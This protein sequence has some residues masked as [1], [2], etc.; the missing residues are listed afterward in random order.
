[1]DEFFVYDKFTLAGVLREYSFIKWTR[2]FNQTGEFIMET[3]ATDDM[4]RYIK[5]GRILYKGVNGEAAIIEDFISIRDALGS[6]ILTV[7]GRF[8]S[9]IL[10]YRVFSYTGTAA[11][12]VIINAIMDQNFISP[13]IANRKIP[14]L[15]RLNY[16]L[17]ADPSITV[18]YSNANALDEITKLCQTNGVGFKVLFNPNNKSFDFSLYEGKNTNAIFTDNFYNVLEQDYYEKTAKERTACIVGG[19]NGLIVDN[20][21]AGLDRKEIYVQADMNASADAAQELGKNTL[22][23]NRRI[24]SFDTVLNMSA[25][26]YPYGTYWDLGDVVTCEDLRWNARITQSVLEV[27]EYYDRGGLHV[28]PVFGDLVGNKTT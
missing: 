10:T 26:Q 14:E 6:E 2:R 1:M 28:T 5:P 3:L 12:S 27:T 23:D 11:L 17:A 21:A 8:L 20:G 7:T 22:R 25:L 13:S 18:E 16:T 4:R 15:R 9:A 19:G 24:T